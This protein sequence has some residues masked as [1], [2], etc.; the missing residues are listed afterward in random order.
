MANR[1][2]V[3]LATLA[4]AACTKASS[5]LDYGSCER[6]PDEIRINELQSIG[7]HNSY[8]RAIPEVELG[9][10][11]L[12]EPELADSLDYSHITLTE[13]LDLGM[14]QIELD[15][16]HDPDGGRFADPLLPKLAAANA[17]GEA[18]DAAGYEQPGLKVMHIQ[19]VD[20]RSHCVLF[21]ECLEEIDIWSRSNPDHTPIL[22]L[23]NA[24]QAQIDV[25][26]ATQA[27]PFDAMAFDGLDEEVRSVFSDDRLIKPDDTRGEADTLREGVLQTGWPTLEDAKGKILFALDESPEVVEAYMRGRSSLEGLPL[28][29]NTID[30]EAD[31]AAY[32]TINDP[33]TEG[34]RISDMVT[35]GFV[36]RTRA[37]A[38]TVEARN[39]DTSRLE[40]A[41]SSGAQYISTDYYLA[42]TDFGDY[43][44]SLPGGEVTR[45]S[46]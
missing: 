23:I 44:A 14:R 24:K 38:D 8:K 18:F 3:G 42:R 1:W 4:L 10:I 9:F 45:C 2:I 22:I 21:T 34:E 25:P 17:G 13:Q 41:L 5:T 27:L 46:P 39:N 30:P 40:A 26:G 36:V 33:K 32:F 6:S 7:S 20:Q 35:S 12:Q 31:H 11:R 37:D 19:D 28:F 43:K 16:F 29:V 15:V